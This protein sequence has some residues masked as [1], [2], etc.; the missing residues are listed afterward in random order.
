MQS[1]AIAHEIE[2]GPKFQPTLV[3]D[4]SSY[5]PES[6]NPLARFA[7]VQQAQEALSV[8]PDKISVQELLYFDALVSMV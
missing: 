2:T 5:L 6:T 4:H 3:A 1:F 7:R 8:A